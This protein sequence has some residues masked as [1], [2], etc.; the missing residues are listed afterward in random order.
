MSDRLGDEGASYWLLASGF[1]RR[2][3]AGQAGQDDRDDIG[4]DDADD[5]KRQRPAPDCA[6]AGPDSTT[7]DRGILTP[8]SPSGAYATATAA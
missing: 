3:P 6:G 5:D 4:D 8:Y 1:R 7:A 2:S